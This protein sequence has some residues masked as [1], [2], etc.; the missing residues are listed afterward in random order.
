MA[1]LPVAST[2]NRK[3]LVML[4]HGSIAEADSISLIVGRN[5][6]VPIRSETTTGKIVFR[7]LRKLDT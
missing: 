1:L 7:E 5:C 4:K 3:G 2:V 6:R